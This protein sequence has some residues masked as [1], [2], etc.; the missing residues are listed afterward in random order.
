MSAGTVN[1]T[2]VRLVRKGRTRAVRARVSYS[3]ASRTVTLDP[4]AA[5]AR[6]ATYTARVAGPRDPSGN[7]LAPGEELELHGPQIVAP[8]PAVAPCTLTCICMRTTVELADPVYRRLRTAAAERGL[9]GYSQ[10]VEEALVEYLDA[11]QQRREVVT[12]IEA[13]EG[14]WGEDDVAELEEARRKAWAQW[15][16]DPSSTP[17]S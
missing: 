9:R 3:G 6:G 12:A 14:A 1:R 8:K 17:T 11:E 5:L 7:A 16:I 15:R 2:S 4:S 13:A 10:I